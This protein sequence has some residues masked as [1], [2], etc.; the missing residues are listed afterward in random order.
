MDIQIPQGVDDWNAA[1][2]EYLPGLMGMT[3]SKVE[4][5]EIIASLDVRTALKAW[6]GFLHAA[7]VVAIADTACGYGALLNLPSGSAGFT[8]AELKSNHLGTAQDGSIHCRAWP[9]HIGRSTQ[10]WDAEVRAGDGEK[11]IA[12]FRCTQMILWPRA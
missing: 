1:G 4:P 5:D 8:T 10:V 6:N 2:K 9:L 7:T 11:A 3:F 12:H